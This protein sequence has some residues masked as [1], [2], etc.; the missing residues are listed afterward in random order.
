MAL[1]TAIGPFV[2]V[3]G[4]NALHCGGAQDACADGGACDAS[5]TADASSVFR[6]AWIPYV[7]GAFDRVFE[8]AG[9]RYLNDHTLLRGDDGRWHVYGIADSSQ[10]MPF[11]ERALLHASAPDLHGPWQ[12][13]AD[14][15]TATG[16]EQVLWAPFAFPTEPHRWVMFYYSGAVPQTLDRA[17]SSDLEQWVRAGRPIPGG[18]DPYV[19]KVSDGWLLYSVGVSASSHG[20]ILVSR[21]ADLEHWSASTVALE[22][23]VASFGWGNLESPTVVV[24]GGEHYLFV[25]RTSDATIDYARTIVFAANDPAHF[26]WSPVTEILA[27][28][29]EVITDGERQ[30][31]TSAGW[32]SSVGQQWRGLTLARLSW[33]PRMP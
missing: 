12:T 28:A 23:P 1:R 25:T 17:D 24:R 7:D 11:A 29:A 30:F 5:V 14:I 2:I 6:S 3:L 33:A 8:P 27:H 19:L 9:T 18:R 13:E 31:I 15:L 16:A 32:T 26:T 22:D 20:Q 4:V 10:G 21:S